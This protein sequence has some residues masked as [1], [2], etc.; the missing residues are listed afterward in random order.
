MLRMRMLREITVMMMHLHG[1]VEEEAEQRFVVDGP[2]D[3]AT[4]G[5][6]RR[7]FSHHDAQPNSPQQQADFR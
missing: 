5:E 3:E 7:R 1:D 6:L 4:F 2:A